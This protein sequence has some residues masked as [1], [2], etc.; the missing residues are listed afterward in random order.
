MHAHRFRVRAPL[1][2]V[3]VFARF[4]SV[5]LNPPPTPLGYNHVRW[6]VMCVDMLHT[7]KHQ[8]MSCTVNI[9]PSPSGDGVNCSAGFKCCL[10]YHKRSHTCSS[11]SHPYDHGVLCFC[12]FCTCACFA[13]F[14]VIFAIPGA[15]STCAHASHV[16]QYNAQFWSS[17]ARIRARVRRPPHSQMPL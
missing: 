12:V 1:L 11:S 4:L 7:N 13:R 9:H 8:I 10:A 16:R 6:P 14:S 15:T 5:M 3:A 17:T 2:G